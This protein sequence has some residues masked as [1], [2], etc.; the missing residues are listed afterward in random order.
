MERLK[1]RL[2]LSFIF[3]IIL[4]RSQILFSQQRPKV[5]VLPFT[6]NAPPYEK[7]DRKAILKNFL[8]E[9]KK[10]GFLEVFYKKLTRR[11]KKLLEKVP[12]SEFLREEG[13]DY[14]IFGSITKIGNFFSL[15]G[16]I[17]DRYGVSHWFS[18]KGRPY[19]ISEKMELFSKFCKSRIFPNLIYQVS[20]EGNKRIEKDAILF[21]IDTKPDT[22][23]EPKV[24]RKDIENIYKMGYFSDIKVLSE[25][26]PYGKKIIYVVRERPT[27][28]EIKI[29]GN[30]ALSKSDV[31]KAFGLRRNSILNFTKIKEGIEKLKKEYADKGYLCAK[32]KYEIEYFGKDWAKVLLK[33]KEGKKLRIKAIRFLGNKNFSAKELKAL[34]E[35]KEKGLI[36]WLLSADIY[37]KD[38]LSR[39]IERIITFYQNNGFINVKV[40]EPK[41]THDERWVY[42]TIPI[43]EGKQFEIG[44]VTLEGDVPEDKEKVLSSLNTKTGEIFNRTLLKK[45]IISLTKIYAD[46]GYAFADVT[47]ITKINREKKAIDVAFK[48]DKGP[49]TH[50]GKI[51]IV[52][53]T[54]TRDRIIRRELRFSEGDIFSS[55]ALARSQQRV[56]NLNYFK[57]VR[58][59]TQKGKKPNTLDVNI[60]VEEKPTGIFSI[61]A[62]FSSAY[63]FI[64]TAK[65][66]QN[67][68]LGLGYRVGISAD[69]GGKYS[70]YDI[71]FTNPCVLDT[72]LSAGLDVYNI[73]KDYT[74]YTKVS[75]GGGLR[76]GYPISEYLFGFMGYRYER[77]KV[78]NVSFHASSYI[79]EQ[80]GETTTSSLV[81]SLTRDTRDI[82]YAPTKGSVVEG[83]I[84]FAGGPLG[85]KNYFIRAEFDAR[86][87]FPLMFGTV[88]M[89]RGRIGYIKPFGGK[90]LPIFERY[91]LGGIDTLRG[92]KDY[93]VGPKD[94]KTGDIIGGNKDII[95]NFEL[96]F[97]LIKEAGLRGV[98]FLDSGNAFK[99]GEGYDLTDLKY[100]I[101]AG[102]RWLS[103]FGPLRIEWGYNLNPGRRQGKSNWQFSMGGNF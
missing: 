89:S 63:S 42:I 9:L 50:F 44:K 66:S 32:I 30:K 75:K 37:K 65:I 47:P 2:F 71:R 98:L 57:E 67:N 54:R 91:F 45:D 74:D 70:R 48:I 16:A 34:M 53:N 78:E 31:E 27:I 96:I 6:V 80:L 95:F 84:E 33:I 61:G 41:V 12:L 28:K 62:G 103:P 81:V 11:E 55:K 39:D 25:E 64:G 10:K 15:D 82:S 79:R 93:A 69:I 72:P 87:Y 19:E 38:K 68:F 18:E 24:V 94:P 43:V 99:E 13:G 100:S 17:F 56:K 3:Y 58:F 60:E 101:G 40:L 76:F 46:R 49:L 4:F 7:I 73:S 20:V 22:F 83:N 5:L 88:F 86:R 14:L 29:S 36:S 23:L 97:P 21:K 8:S 1:N 51:T 92:Y 26:T 90:R 85:G 102:I 35:T 52:G 59:N 77:V